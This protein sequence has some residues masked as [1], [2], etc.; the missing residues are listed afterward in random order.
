MS[1]EHSRETKKDGLDAAYAI[2]QQ[3]KP[4][5]TTLCPL[6]RHTVAVLRP[7]PLEPARTRRAG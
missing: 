2:E 7:I 5:W 3:W 1:M 4:C 6:Q